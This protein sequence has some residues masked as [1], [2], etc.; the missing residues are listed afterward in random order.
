MVSGNIDYSSA[1]LLDS[2]L[3]MEARSLMKSKFPQMVEYFIEDTQ[4]YIAY[5]EK[6]LSD[7]NTEAM[8]PP[9][10]TTKSSSKQLGAL[11]LSLVAQTIEHEARDA[12]LNNN[13]PTMVPTL[14]EELKN[15]FEATKQAFAAV[16]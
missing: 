5:I 15:T 12:I 14:L 7:G 2:T 8:V 4:G 10:H 1:P 9:A 13:Q 16:A 6:A 3:L 11:R